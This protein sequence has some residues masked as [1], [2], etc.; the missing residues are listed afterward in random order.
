MKRMDWEAAGAGV[1]YAF[2]GAIFAP[3]ASRLMI[4]AVLL[5]CQR[6]SGWGYYGDNRRTLTN[7]WKMLPIE[8]QAPSKKAKE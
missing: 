8:Y 3:K 1:L 5:I 7:N 4:N 2:M 6:E